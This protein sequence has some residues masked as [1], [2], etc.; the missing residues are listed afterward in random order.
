[1]REIKTYGE[2]NNGKLKIYKK[3][4]FLELIKELGRNQITKVQII[5][6]IMY[7]KRSNLQNGYY[8]GYLLPL[9]VEG[10]Y[11]TNGMRCSEDQAHEFLK[12]KFLGADF[13]NLDTGEIESMPGSTK[14]LSTVEF[15]EYCIDCGNFMIEWFNVK[16]VLEPNEQ[17]TLNFNRNEKVT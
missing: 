16:E 5:I 3:F 2:I 1:M 14:I 7:R 10:F 15:I 13:T 17:S 12:G 8:R 9:F 4:A 11:D 6:K